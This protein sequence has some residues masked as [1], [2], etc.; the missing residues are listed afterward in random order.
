MK[1]L[2]KVKVSAETSA[3]QM[4]GK[5]QCRVFRTEGQ[6]T[7]RDRQV[8]VKPKPSPEIKKAQVWYKIVHSRALSHTVEPPWG[9]CLVYPE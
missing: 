4:K 5:G 8:C 1:P 9:R 2:E 7:V 3:F 6:S